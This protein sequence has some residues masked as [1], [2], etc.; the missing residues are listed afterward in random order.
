MIIFFTS[1]DLAA[2]LQ[3]WS[4]SST[5]RGIDSTRS[6]LCRMEEVPKDSCSY[7]F[8]AANVTLTK[9]TCSLFRV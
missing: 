6:I 4:D 1:F 5:S 8:F 2:V 7:L 3:S 9:G